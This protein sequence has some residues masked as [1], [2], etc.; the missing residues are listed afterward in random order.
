M[1]T[2]PDDRDIAERDIANRPTLTL[3]YWERDFHVPDGDVTPIRFGTRDAAE[4]ADEHPYYGH[5]RDG[6]Y[7]GEV[8]QVDREYRVGQDV[9]VWAFGNRRPG[10]VTKLG[11]SRVTVDYVRNREGERSER[12]FTAGEIYD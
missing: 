9:K 11:R 6:A 4:S 1:T 10:K 3:T 5:G 8:R 2:W 12:A 7:L